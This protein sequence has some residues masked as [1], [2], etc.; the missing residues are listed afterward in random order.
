MKISLR[1]ARRLENRINEKLRETIDTTRSLNIFQHSRVDGSSGI[2]RVSVPDIAELVMEARSKTEAEIED[3]LALINVRSRLRREIG[4]TNEDFGINENVAR[5]K[6]ILEESAFIQDIILRA[7]NEDE[8]LDAAGVA[9]KIRALRQNP[10]RIS[11]DYN[12]NVSIST[13]SFAYA[14]SLRERKRAL[15]KALEEVEDKLAALNTG[16]VITLSE[17]DEK[18]LVK[19][20]LL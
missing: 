7:S 3:R 19:L 14:D 6:A 18:F 11:Y 8:E 20:G 13:I 9:N 16:T 10:S 1:A 12:E 15:T 5:R 17:A 2:E 4:E